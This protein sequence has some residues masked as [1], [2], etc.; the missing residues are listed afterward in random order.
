MAALHLYTYD[1]PPAERD[2][3][4]AGRVLA[5]DGVIAY[6]TDLNWAIGCD[7]MNPKALDR[8]YQLKPTHPK[9]LPFSLLVSSIS[10]ASEYVTIDNGAYRLLKRAWPGPFT[11][12]LPATRAFPR[13]LKDKRRVVGIRIPA[14]PLIAAVVDKL[15][16]PLATTSV[17]P[18]PP[19]A[20]G[21]AEGTVRAR[22]GYEVMEAFGHGVDLV[23]DL[24]TELPG[25]ES[26]IVDL[27][28]GVPEIVRRG[29]GDLSIFEGG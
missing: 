24:G 14:S 4:R 27:T 12:L 2:V 3:E 29:A 5:D 1:D 19:H 25:L 22:F 15:G 16:R 20:G 13:Q 26:T 7:V 18:L 11:V 10:M 23:L 21:D 28:S 8:V 17:P 6:P 9:D